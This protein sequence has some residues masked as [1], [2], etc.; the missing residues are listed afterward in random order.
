MKKSAGD[1]EGNVGARHQQIIGSDGGCNYRRAPARRD[2]QTVT[3]LTAITFEIHCDPN[4][5][6]PENP[7]I[8]QNR[9]EKISEILN[10]WV[11][12]S[13][14]AYQ[15]YQDLSST[16]QEDTSDAVSALLD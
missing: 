3:S 16:S 2:R 15:D 6:T 7:Q 4:I 14:Y 8:Y 10:I 5:E 11:F 9:L 1:R 13:E 12:D